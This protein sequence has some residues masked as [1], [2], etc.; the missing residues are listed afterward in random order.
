M[1]N[2]PLPLVDECD[3]LT[4]QPVYSNW[5]RLCISLINL[6]CS[7]VYFKAMDKKANII[8][9]TSGWLVFLSKVQLRFVSYL[10][11]Y[12][13]LLK[14]WFSASRSYTESDVKYRV[15]RYQISVRI[16][17][18]LNESRG[19]KNPEKYKQR[20]ILV[21]PWSTLEAVF[22]LLFNELS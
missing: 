19:G 11:V 18:Y 3:L 7:L 17:Q 21:D 16:F 1:Q 9:P 6:N 12:C 2:K 15:Q 22:L 8:P 10:N 14:N 13:R 4:V 20:Y 5:T